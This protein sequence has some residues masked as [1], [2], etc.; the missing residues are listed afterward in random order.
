MPLDELGLRLIPALAGV[1][2]I[3]VVLPRRPAPGWDAGGAVRRAPAD[4]Q[5][6]STSTSHSM[7]G[8]GLS[9]FSSPRSIRTPSISGSPGATADLLALGIAAAVLA[10]LSHPVA[11][12]LFGGLSIWLVATY[13]QP[14]TTSGLWRQRNV[15]LGSAGARPARRGHRRSL[16]PVLV[17]WIAGA[18]RWR[19]RATTCSTFPAGRG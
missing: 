6:A 7:R 5:R 18:R 4:G 17:E 10:V 11:V 13:F 1:L 9:S 3:P 12:L 8:T 19:Q 16:L 15:Q 2:A 14:A